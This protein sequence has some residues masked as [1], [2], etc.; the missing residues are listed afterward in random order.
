MAVRRTGAGYAIAADYC[1]G[2][3]LCVRECPTGSIV[4]TEELR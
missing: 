2:C 3:G 1:K 4:M